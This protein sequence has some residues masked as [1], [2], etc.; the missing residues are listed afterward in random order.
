M[1]RR[2]IP[3]KWDGISRIDRARIC[4]GGRGSE[5]AEIGRIFPGRPPGKYGR[6]EAIYGGLGRSGRRARRIFAGRARIQAS[7]SRG[8]SACR[9]SAAFSAMAAATKIARLSSARTLSQWAT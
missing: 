3:G 8:C 9:W 6:R 2:L 7:G 5:R 1:R 4:V